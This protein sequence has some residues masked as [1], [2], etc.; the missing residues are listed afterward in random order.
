[1]LSYNFDIKIVYQYIYLK[2]SRSKRIILMLYYVDDIFLT[3]N[4]SEFLFETK[5]TLSYKFN[6][7][8][9]GETHCILGIEIIGDKSRGILG[10]SLEG[11]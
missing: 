11:L 7:K 6:M 5:Y 3:A 4:D 8:N 1:M 10:L 2:V 9:F